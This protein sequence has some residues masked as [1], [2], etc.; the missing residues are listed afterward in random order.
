MSA[1]AKK[2]RGSGGN[3]LKL[4]SGG[5]QL[6]QLGSQNHLQ[7][8][9]SAQHPFKSEA[10]PVPA[11]GGADAF[12]HVPHYQYATPTVAS[13]LAPPP[14]LHAWSA[15][16]SVPG[17]GHGQYAGYPQPPQSSS[18]S[19]P[20]TSVGTPLLPAM[21]QHN[22]PTTPISGYAP[23]HSGLNLSTANSMVGAMAWVPASCS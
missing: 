6:Q 3:G 16:T 18:S 15:Q 11:I 13:V 22:S 4:T 14:P 7:H 19:S 12:R 20:P 10:C 1:K 17:Y 23:P 9:Q 21:H 2:P 5:H 8:H